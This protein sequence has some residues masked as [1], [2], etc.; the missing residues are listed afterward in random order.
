MDREEDHSFLGWSQLDN[1][2]AGRKRKTPL[3]HQ[4]DSNAQDEADIEASVD[5]GSNHICFTPNSA[6]VPEP[7]MICGCVLDFFQNVAKAVVLF[8]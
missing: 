8:D 1:R 4:A 2:I 3:E 6:A 5:D 7:L